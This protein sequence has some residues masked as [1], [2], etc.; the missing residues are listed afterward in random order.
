MKKVTSSFLLVGLLALAILGFAFALSPAPIA[1]DSAV[2]TVAALFRTAWNYESPEDTFINSQVT[3]RKWWQVSM[4]SLPDETGAPVTALS[5]TLES[6]MAFDNLET[7]NLVTT[8]PPNVPEGSDAGVWVD[9]LHDSNT[10]PVSFTPGFDASRSVDKTKFTEPD[11]QTLT[12]TLTPQEVTDGFRVLVQAEENDIVS[13]VITSPTSGDGIYLMP[14]GYSLHIDPTDLELNTTWTIDVTIQVTPKEPEVTFLPYV[15][16]GQQG[17]VASGSDSGNSLSH[18]V[19]DPSDGVGDWT[20]RADGLYEWEWGESLSKQV[21]WELSY[22]VVRGNGWGSTPATVPGGN[23]VS[24]SFME[25]RHY[26]VSGDSFLNK[27]VTVEEWWRT[28]LLN[29]SDETGASVTGLRLTLDSE[30]SLVVEKEFLT[31]RGP[32]TYEWFLGDIP[33]G[34]TVVHTGGYWGWDAYVRRS[35]TSKLVP[36][37]DVSRSLDKTVFSA[38][39]VQTLT[40]TVTLREESIDTVTITV[41]TDEDVFVDPVVLSYSSAS[42]GE[43]NIEQDGHRSSISFVPVELNTPMTV[44]VTIQ[45]TPKI[46]LVH[47][48][49]GTTIG[50]DRVSV[51]DEGITTGGSVSFATEVGT[52]TWSADGDYVWGWGIRISPDVIVSFSRGGSSPISLFIL[53]V[54]ILGAIILGIILYR[55]RRRRVSA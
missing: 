28:N 54:I 35:S 43:V 14:E 48:K 2:N 8:G 31:M 29:I 10:V 1:A 53:V 32:P 26:E 44:T 47:Y 49:P 34:E 30:D 24:V 51:P 33:D 11:A 17:M 9:S 20:W 21:I 38:Q 23:E 25:Q 52:W 13:T 19:G 15:L 42:G 7:D 27:E 55:R 12:I 3:G 39:G 50:T 40:V 46:P 36:G 41:H 5:L 18:P 22:G 4:M 45:V 16:I 37:Y 6:A